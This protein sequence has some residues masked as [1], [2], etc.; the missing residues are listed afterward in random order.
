MIYFS[1]MEKSSP[2]KYFSIDLST[3]MLRLLN[4]GICADKSILLSCKPTRGILFRGNFAGKRTL[5]TGVPKRARSNYSTFKVSLVVGLVG[6]LLYT[7]NDSVNRNVKYFTYCAERIGTVT[8]ATARC[9]KLYKAVLSEEHPSDDEKRKALADVHKRAALITLKALEKN[10]GIYIKLGQH[11]SALTYLLPPEWTETMIP[12]QDRCPRSYI[13][14]LEK[15]FKRD[16]GKELS[17]VFSEFD[18]TPIGTASLAQVHLGRLRDSGKKVAVKLQHPS[19]ED[20]VPLDIFLTEKVFSLINKVFPE[21]PLLWLSDE[22]QKSIYVELDFTNEAMNA[23]MTSRY[24]DNYK[25]ETALRVPRVVFAQERILVMEY[26]AGA[27]LDDTRYLEENHISP[28]EISCCLSHLFNNM[29]FTPNVGL[30]CDPHGGNL[31][32]RK[33]SKGEP[34]NGHNFEIILYDHGLYRNVPTPLKHYYAHFWLA[35]LKKDIPELRKYCQKLTGIKDEQEFLIFLAA[36]TGRHPLQALLY[37]ISSR[38]TKQEMSTLQKELQEEQG[39][40]ERLM[41][42]LDSAPRV[43]LMILKTNDLIRNLD[44]K[45]HNP[46]GP[47][48]SFLIMANYCARSVYD[49]ARE[50]NEV[51]YSNKPISRFVHNIGA[52]FSYQRWVSTLFIYDLFMIIRNVREW[53]HVI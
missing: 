46:L 33:K 35:L 4:R 31:A 29:I 39:V 27:R 34:G 45:L 53:L 48:R 3:G 49:E 8:L 1:V 5:S 42:I 18:P 22:M 28:F 16:T 7:T 11:I 21:Y 32:I 47:E 25:K 14:E 30:H 50:Q 41:G 17:E 26:V 24:F 6:S 36:I 52:W 19:L 37:D 43:V 13:D 9:F 12:L 15:M 2:L 38:R 51:K 44:E 23:E 20:F 40:L 10:G